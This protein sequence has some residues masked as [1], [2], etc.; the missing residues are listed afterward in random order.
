MPKKFRIGFVLI[1]LS[2]FV[3]PGSGFAGGEKSEQLSAEAVQVRDFVEQ[4]LPKKVGVRITRVV[5]NQVPDDWIANDQNGILVEIYRGSLKVL[6]ENERE[7]YACR[8]YFLP[9]DWIGILPAQNPDS[10]GQKAKRL[11][12]T[13]THKIYIDCPWEYTNYFVGLREGKST[14]QD[15]YLWKKSQSVFEEKQKEM[16]DKVEALLKQHCSNDACRSEAARSL[17]IM[18][19][20]A[21]E[22]FIDCAKRLHDARR[23]C[24]HSLG[25]VGGRKADDT[26]KRLIDSSDTTDTLIL[27]ASESLVRKMGE[28]AGRYITRGLKKTTNLLTAEQLVGMLVQ[29]GYKNSASSVYRWLKKDA[30]V[31]H[32]SVFINALAEFEYRGA[33][34]RIKKICDEHNLYSEGLSHNREYSIS[35]VYKGNMTFA[36]RNYLGPWGKPTDG[37]R[38]QLIPPEKVVKEKPAYVVLVLRND[39]GFAV[40]MPTK[41]DITFVVDGKELPADHSDSV[42]HSTIGTLKD[43]SFHVLSMKLP[44]ALK[45][46]GKLKLQAKSPYNQVSFSEEPDQPD[47]K[48]LSGTI[49]SNEVEI[50]VAE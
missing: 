37:L 6:D 27:R 9:H 41:G 28:K 39:S 47:K 17:S 1:F 44:E 2:W 32:R 5:E 23:S 34:S 19:V 30:I 24:I 48:P 13:D 29:I 35:G 3:L 36:C 14:E 12:W 8:I 49:L 42:D 38:F 15:R 21:V 4:I 31:D 20:P 46:P 7:L 22:T 16:E 50:E 26:L 18:K 43:R 45:Q 10:G 25:F 11:Y 33:K 40:S